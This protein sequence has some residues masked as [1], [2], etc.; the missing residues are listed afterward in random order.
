M[1]SGS[2]GE[3]EDAL[4]FANAVAALNCRRLG[5]RGGPADGRGSGAVVVTPRAPRRSRR[6]PGAR[7]AGGRPD[8][9]RRVDGTRSRDFAAG[10]AAAGA[11]CRRSV[12]A[13]GDQRPSANPPPGIAICRGFS[14]RTTGRLHLAVDWSVASKTGRVQRGRRRP[15]EPRRRRPRQVRRS[16]HAPSRDGA[17][18]TAG[19][20]A[21]R[22]AA[23]P[24]PADRHRLCRHQGSQPGRDRDSRSAGAGRAAGPGDQAR[25]GPDGRRR[26]HAAG[27]RSRRVRAPG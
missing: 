13:R 24:V 4:S 19:D 25:T 2:R 6:P 23:R 18:R 3:V 27:H 22:V 16:G 11:G 20:C 5:A 14:E 7:T 12:A 1:P 8:L 9:Q 17:G 21:I 15:S 10:R 26:G